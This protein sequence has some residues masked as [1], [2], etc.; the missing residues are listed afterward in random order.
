MILIPKSDL[1]KIY[2]ESRKLAQKLAQKLAEKSLLRVKKI[3]SK[4]GLESKQKLKKKQTK[5]FCGKKRLI[6]TQTYV[7][8]SFPNAFIATRYL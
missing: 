6:Y 1:K 7:A 3:G 2:L 8:R 4:I 5:S